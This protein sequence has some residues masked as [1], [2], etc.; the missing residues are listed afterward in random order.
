MADAEHPIPGFPVFLGQPQ[1]PN[2]HTLICTTDPLGFTITLDIHRW[3]DH[4]IKRHPEMS[5]HLERVR[6]TIEKPQMILA[7]EGTTTA[8]YYKLTGTTY[9]NRD[10]LGGLWVQQTPHRRQQVAAN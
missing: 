8:Y 6:S 4:I 10:D 5:R 2:G 9:R 1:K 3:E 7:S